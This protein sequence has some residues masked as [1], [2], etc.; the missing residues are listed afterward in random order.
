[1]LI[2][3]ARRCCDPFT[4]CCFLSVQSAAKP[5]RVLGLQQIAIGGLDKGP[6]QSLWVRVYWSNACGIREFIL[7]CVCVCVCVCVRVCVRV[8]QT[9]PD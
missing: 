6:L 2:P 4:R 5:F 1:M 8:G 3:L 7:V 9:L